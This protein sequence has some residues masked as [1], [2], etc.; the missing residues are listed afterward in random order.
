MGGVIGK[1]T[2]AVSSDVQILIH[3]HGMVRVGW[4]HVLTL[5]WETKNEPT[6]KNIA[7]ILLGRLSR[8]NKAR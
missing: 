5:M 6:I 7:N 2:L 1:R 3:M 4:C 8:R